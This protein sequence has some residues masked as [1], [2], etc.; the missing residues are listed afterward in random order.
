[1]N[2]PDELVALKTRLDAELEVIEETLVDSVSDEQ[3]DAQ[4]AIHERLEDVERKLAG[5][6]GYDSTQKALAGCFVSIG[7]DGSL[8]LDKGLVKPEH[9]KLLAKL[10]GTDDSEAKPVKAKTGHGLSESLCRDLALDRLQVAKVEI[11]R[12]PAIALDLLAFRAA[13]EL[14]G[15]DEPTD[16]PSVEFTLPKPGKDRE[17][18]VADSE[19]I[20][21]RQALPVG[22]LKA[23][24]EAERFEAFCALPQESR[25]A[26]LA[27]CVALTLQ[28][29]LGPAHLDDATAYDAALSRTTG[30]L[31]AY[32]RPTKGNFLARLTRG[33]LLAVGREV[34]G[35]PWSQSRA[36][37][38][39][40][41]LVEQLDRAFSDPEKSGRTPAQIER[42]KHW[43]PSGMAF[44]IAAAKPAKSNKAR[45]AA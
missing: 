39:K 38:K 28:P 33:Q 31:A 37:V 15:D 14:L 1:M 2:V 18:S 44:G 8:F 6:V 41:S 10:L 13:S 32:W 19:L 22:W 43:L 35:E 45:K 11:A 40:S 26:L 16:G 24:S 25:F 42:L 12:H 27:F 34:L 29:K 17:P 30:Q 23:K 9:R 3:L 20:A 4:Q 36:N 5:Y 7:Q 21:I